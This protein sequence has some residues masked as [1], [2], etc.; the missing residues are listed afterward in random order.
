MM[1]AEEV[2]RQGYTSAWTPFHVF[3]SSISNTNIHLNFQVA[4]NK[5]QSQGLW[6]NERS[7]TLGIPGPWAQP[8]DFPAKV[9]APRAAQ[10]ALNFVF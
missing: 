1:P 10:A 2:T 4:R 3:R 8:Q 6:G 9:N 5:T 7:E